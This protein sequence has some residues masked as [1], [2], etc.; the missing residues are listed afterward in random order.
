MYG[1]DCT[2]VRSSDFFSSE[3]RRPE[4]K[5]KRFSRCAAST[6]LN[7]VTILTVLSLLGKGRERA[8]AN[9]PNWTGIGQERIADGGSSDHRT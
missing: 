2:H 1:V 8:K 3:G 4:L 7:Q 9:S 6:E 5:Y